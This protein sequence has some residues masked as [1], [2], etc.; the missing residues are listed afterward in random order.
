MYDDALAAFAC[1]RE[2]HRRER[3]GVEIE[4]V[5]RTLDP[6][7]RLAEPE[8][9]KVVA[10]EEGET[11]FELLGVRAAHPEADPRVRIGKDG[12]QDVLIFRELAEVLMGQDEA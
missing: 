11:V 7:D 10:V 12:A 6:A 8:V 4:V 9:L 2:V 5:L 3:L 1:H